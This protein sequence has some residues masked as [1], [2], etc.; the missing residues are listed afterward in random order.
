MKTFCVTHFNENCKISK[1]DSVVPNP[2][3]HQ[4]LIQIKA[5]SL[6]PSDVSLIGGEFDAP[7]PSVLG[8][9]FSGKVIE[10][11]KYTTKHK[12]GDR[13]AGLTFGNC[14][15][16]S[17][18]EY[19]V[20]D[21]ELVFKLPNNLSFESAAAIPVSFLTAN[22]ITK[23]IKKTDRVLIFG[24]SGN[25]GKAVLSMIVNES[26]VVSC[27]KKQSSVDRLKKLFPTKPMPIIATSGLCK[28]DL[29]SNLKKSIANG[30][31]DCIVDLVGCQYS[32][33]YLD[34]C[35]IG[36]KIISVVP[37]INLMEF[38]RHKHFRSNIFFK[39]I[40]L[41]HIFVGA[42]TF[43]RFKVIRHALANEFEEILKFIVKENI[44]NFHY[45]CHKV[46]DC[47]LIEVA[48]KD[49][50]NKVLHEKKVF[51]F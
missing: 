44:L 13:V 42:E 38:E 47:N 5:F 33:L 16:G 23:H 21:E 15:N 1:L 46:E 8:I 49:I 2:G 37:D 4:V 9:E 27:V 17:A 28:S 32:E 25:V 51:I 14:S 34:V 7:L 30:E 20:I 48:L 29:N 22:K 11:G 40:S 43:S 19:V 18:A 12:V 45:V 50:K 41:H 10:L 36:A 39:N 35:A 6:N 26:Q 3:N 31:F 24:A